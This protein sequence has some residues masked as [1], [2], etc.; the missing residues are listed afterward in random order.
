MCLKKVF[1]TPY[2]QLGGLRLATVPFSVTVSSPFSS[3]KRKDFRRWKKNTIY[4]N[5]HVHRPQP[6]SLDPA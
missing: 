1:P 2:I 5:G 4:S 6:F 3:N